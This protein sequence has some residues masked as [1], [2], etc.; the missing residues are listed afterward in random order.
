MTW[1]G[2]PI[3]DLLAA[4]LIEARA[5]RVSLQP[6]FKL[7]SGKYSPVYFDCR[8][9]ISHPSAMTIV[10]GAFQWFVDHSGARVD[11]IAGGESAGIP[12]AD[13]LAAVTGKPLVYVRKQ[14]RQHGTG[15]AIEGAPVPGGNVLLVED[16]ITDGVSKMAFVHGLR[17]AG[18]VVDHCLVVLDREQGGAEV[19]E[20]AGVALHSLTTAA[21]VLDFGRRSARLRPEDVE[22]ALKYL[23]APDAWIPPDTATR[24]S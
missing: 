23:D 13:R 8:Q 17:D 18:M 4:V 2:L 9:L 20:A 6:L 12:F 22:T 24:E 14:Q 5:V 16:L 7:T 11:V 19:L 1:C 10:T 21:R 3:D 15:A